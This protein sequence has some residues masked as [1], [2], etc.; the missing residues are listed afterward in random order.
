MSSSASPVPPLT[1]DKRVVLITGAA[2]GLGSA[3]A[4]A[5]ARAGATVVLLG[6]KLA[7]LNRLYDAITAA[8]PEPL[9]YPLDL[10]GADPDDYAHRRP[11]R[12]DVVVLEPAT[13]AEV[14]PQAD[15]IG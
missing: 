3:A 9:L 7:P 5:C 12:T 6:R 4:M 15:G 13:A 10:E 2:G 11:G 8:G 1:L 14:R